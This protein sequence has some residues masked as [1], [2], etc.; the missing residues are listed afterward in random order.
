MYGNRHACLSYWAK[1]CNILRMWKTLPSKGSEQIDS[2]MCIV[3]QKGWCMP[4]PKIKMAEISPENSFYKDWFPLVPKK[5]PETRLRCLW[6]I[7]SIVL[8][9]KHQ[10]KHVSQNMSQTPLRHEWTPGLSHAENAESVT[11]WTGTQGF[12]RWY[13]QYSSY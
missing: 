2:T 5:V 7:F 3:D 13:I 8:G 11:T 9:S 12:T 6:H 10:W 1:H 4:D